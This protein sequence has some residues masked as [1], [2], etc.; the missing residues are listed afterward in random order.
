MAY[1]N[2]GDT[3]NFHILYW[4]DSLFSGIYLVRGL[5]LMAKSIQALCPKQ[6]KKIRESCFTLLENQL[7]I[8]MKLNMNTKQEQPWT[9]AQHCWVGAFIWAKCLAG[10]NFPKSKPRWTHNSNKENKC[11]SFFQVIASVQLNCEYVWED[12]MIA[13]PHSFPGCTLT[14]PCLPAPERWWWS[15]P[16]RYWQRRRGKPQSRPHKRWM[17]PCGSLGL[18]PG[19]HKWH[20]QSAWGPW[21]T[22]MH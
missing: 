2:G 20:P 13:A 15:K 4:K 7:C 16:Q 19:L 21:N 22:G 12:Q 3:T 17:S 6:K 10:S 5:A 1:S 8:N 11:N 14:W 9:W 18:D